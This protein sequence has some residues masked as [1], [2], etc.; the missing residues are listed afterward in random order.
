MS[1]DKCIKKQC[2][3][4]L[5]KGKGIGGLDLAPTN[6]RCAVTG[7]IVH[8][9]KECPKVAEENSMDPCLRRGDEPLHNPTM[10]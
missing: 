1:T 10:E 2:P 7:R 4:Y 5:T 3:D 9:M 8:R 6:G